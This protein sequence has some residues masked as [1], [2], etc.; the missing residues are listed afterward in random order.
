[1]LEPDMLDGRKAGTWSGHAPW[2]LAPVVVAGALGLVGPGP[3]CDAATGQDDAGVRYPRFER[4]NATQTL[5]FRLP[6]GRPRL[7][8]DGEFAR[9]LQ[10]V[11]W[12]PAPKAE[13]WDEGGLRLDFELGSGG[14]VWLTA[15]PRHAGYV[16]LRA[17]A[18]GV[19]LDAWQW[20]WP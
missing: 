1:M 17:R 16:R 6:P 3:L 10:V 4:A 20:V 13:A 8:L 5:A 9:N 18:G 14:E 2:L 12:L 19:P 15:R 7:W 11:S